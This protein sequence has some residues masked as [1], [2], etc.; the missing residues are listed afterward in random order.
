MN[1]PVAFVAGRPVGR[2]HPCFVI[3]EI[4][5]N[6]NGS[7]ELAKRLV[8][9]AS[10]AGCDIVKFQKRTPKKCVPAEHQSILRETPWGIVTYLEYRQRIELDRNGYEEIA[11]HCRTRGIAWFA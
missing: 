11:R 4:G 1:A 2:G 9:S 10:Q 6:H 5:I 8:D 7:V 3:A